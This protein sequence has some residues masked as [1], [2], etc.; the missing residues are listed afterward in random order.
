MER[1]RRRC[2]NQL[3]LFAVTKLTLY[4]ADIQTTQTAIHSMDPTH[5]HQGH[6]PE[7][8]EQKLNKHEELNKHPCVLTIRNELVV[9]N[10]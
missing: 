7:K 6:E 4:V 1:G 8:K 10:S 3:C 9:T 2:K 5:S